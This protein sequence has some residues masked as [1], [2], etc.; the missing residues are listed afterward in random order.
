MELATAVA[1]KSDLSEAL[2]IIFG[3]KASG[4]LR[5]ISSTVNG[6]LAIDGGEI[7]GAINTFTGSTGDGALQ[8][9]MNSGVAVFQ[10][11]ETDV[12][13]DLRQ[14]L[15][16][17]TGSYVYE[18]G[19]RKPDDAQIEK[20]A[21][22]FQQQD[23]SFTEGKQEKSSLSSEQQKLLGLYARLN[24]EADRRA[25][26][27]SNTEFSDM[28]DGKGLNELQRREL[29]RATYGGDQASMQAFVD[30][31]AQLLGDAQAALSPQQVQMLQ[32]VYDQLSDEDARE[33]FLKTNLQM[34][35]DAPVGRGSGVTQQLRHETA[36]QAPKYDEFI[37]ELQNLGPQPHGSRATSDGE[38]EK[39]AMRR[40]SL[41]EME[42][43][44]REELSRSGA[45]YFA[46]EEPAKAPEVV[47]EKPQMKLPMPV[48]IAG[49]LVVLAI[50]AL[51]LLS[52]RP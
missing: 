21:V 6:R 42:A 31:Q 40:R 5:V 35:D 25:F 13:A 20:S 41:E 51:M 2:S 16:V 32:D 29:G 3:A 1:E 26:L 11:I 39:P 38:R 49:A 18:L 12:P 37:P 45:H 9:F 24:N 46:V 28:M 8:E 30:F 48:I 43:I 19:Q 10:F 27:Q 22:E 44:E 14:S 15:S 36:K 52:P 50:I 34:N 47:P 23:P 7:L 4:I 17:D 33:S